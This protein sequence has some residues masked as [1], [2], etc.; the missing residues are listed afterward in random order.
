MLES[1]HG[2]RARDIHNPTTTRLQL[3]PPIP[4]TSPR[5]GHQ[6]QSGTNSDDIKHHLLH[7]SIPS[8]FAISCSIRSILNSSFP[9]LTSFRLATSS[10]PPRDQSLQSSLPLPLRLSL[11]LSIL[12]TQNP[13]YELKPHQAHRTPR[14]SSSSPGLRSTYVTY[15]PASSRWI[16]V[17]LSY[18]GARLS[19]TSL[20]SSAICSVKLVNWQKFMNFIP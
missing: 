4:H 14:S 7:P 2:F 12:G 8:I 5:L 13:P 1:E 6:N 18:V 19:H 3:S 9:I 11:S 17:S 16:I 15:Y 20:I 10:I